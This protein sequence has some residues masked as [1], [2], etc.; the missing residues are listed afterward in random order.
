MS[1][2]ARLAEK[3]GFMREGLLRAWI[4]NHGTRTDMIVR[5]LLRDEISR[6]SG[7]S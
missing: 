6:L 4:D 5:S 2:Q 7:G 3:V 1:P